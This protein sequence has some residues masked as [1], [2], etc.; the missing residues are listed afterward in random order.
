MYQAEQAEH[1]NFENDFRRPDD[2][3]TDGALR[4]RRQKVDRTFWH[5]NE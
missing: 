5:E 1:R 4:H 2:F 3:L